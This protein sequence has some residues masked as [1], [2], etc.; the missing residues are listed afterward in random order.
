MIEIVNRK[1]GEYHDAVYVGRGSPLGN[2]FSHKSGTMAEFQVE[3]RDEAVEKY[4]QWLAGQLREGGWAAL[5]F[6]EL[7]QFYKDFGYLKLAC[8]CVPK[9]CHAEVIA[10]MVKE[11]ARQTSDKLEKQGEAVEEA[12]GRQDVQEQDLAG[13]AVVVGAEG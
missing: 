13:E 1:T 8:W 12:E 9:R 6:H 4:R 7:V 11:Y 10:E 5:T 3:T 2:P